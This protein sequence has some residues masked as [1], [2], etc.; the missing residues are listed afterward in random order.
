V[1]R[2]RAWVYSQFP[3]LVRDKSET[4]TKVMSAKSAPLLQKWHKN[5]I[6]KAIQKIGLD[7]REFDLDDSGTEVRIRNKRSGSYFIAGGRPGHHVGRYVIGEGIEVPYEVYSWD[8]LLPR[9]DHWLQFVKLDLD[10][11]DLWADLQ[12]EVKL[13]EAGS[14]EI[15]DNTPFTAEEQKEI[16]RRLDKLAKDVSQA[17]SLSGAETKA[18]HAKLDYL[19]DASRR[20]GRK[21][22]LNAFIGVTLGF[23]LAVALPSESARG[24]LLTFF[25]SIGLLY[26]ELSIE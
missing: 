25:R 1:R 7:P 11:P 23:I 9:V 14:N 22:W 6:F 17:H 20:L 10:T 16:A 4:Y 2:C 19:V 26:P 21:D 3:S 12:R 8:A 24:I 15:T 13:L 5:D 18:L